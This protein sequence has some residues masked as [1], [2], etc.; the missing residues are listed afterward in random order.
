MAKRGAQSELTDRNWD[1]EEEPEEA[2]EFVKASAD[3]LKDRHIIKAR[4]KQPGGEGNSGSAFSGFGGFS[5]KPTQ[6]STPLFGGSNLF[7]TESKIPAEEKKESQNEKEPDKRKADGTDEES[8]RSPTK[9]QKADTNG[10]S[11]EQNGSDSSPSQN[12]YLSNL[13]SLNISVSNWIK[14]H[15]DKNPYCILTPIFKDYENHLS[16]MEKE[17][18][19]GGENGSSESTT[20]KKE[21][22]AKPMEEDTKPLPKTGLT[23]GMGNL[24]TAKDTPQTSLFTGF[25][26]KPSTTGTSAVAPGGFSFAVGSSQPSSSSGGAEGKEDEEYVPPQVETVEHKEEGALYS[27]KCKLFYQKDG[28]W[29]ERG[30]GFLHLKK[31]EDKAQ[32]LVRADTTLGNI[33]LNIRLSE[34]MPLSRQGKNNVSMMCI[35]NPAIPKVPDDKP[36]PMLIRVKTGEDAD[37]LLEKM[38]EI[39][40]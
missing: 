38:K 13:K 21:E 31:N 28:A 18:K 23:F 35:V 4:R 16:E 36:I 10:S 15:L 32:L 12:K 7:K 30:V 19:K 9:R 34:S 5:F 37:E 20:L 1:Q 40:T 3:K 29:T 2:G 22:S 39:R 27:K 24:N 17:R 6:T 11:N 14:Q 25:G 33:L 8:G 26:L